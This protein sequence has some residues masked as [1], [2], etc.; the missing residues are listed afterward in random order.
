MADQQI[1]TEAQAHAVLDV[2]GKHTDKVQVAGDPVAEAARRKSVEDWREAAKKD[3]RGAAEMMA[4]K[5]DIPKPD[6]VKKLVA[7]AL[8]DIDP[9]HPDFAKLPQAEKDRYIETK[10]TALAA[11]MLIEGKGINGLT[12]SPE[13]SKELVNI[14]E[15][16]RQLATITPEGKALFAKLNPTE[17]NALIDALS[18]DPQVIE[19]IRTKFDAARES[20]KIPEKME[21]NLRKDMEDAKDTLDLAEKELSDL[22]ADLKRA[23]DEYHE[24]SDPTTPRGSALDTLHQE[25]P[26][27]QNNANEANAKLAAANDKVNELTNRHKEESAKVYPDRDQGRID[28]AK[29]LMDDA[30]LDRS[31]IIGE[32]KMW[33]DRLALYNNLRQ[34]RDNARTEAKSL[35]GQIL[36]Q[37]KAVREA[38][39]TYTTADKAHR[40]A[41]K[42]LNEARETFAKDM[43]GVIKEGMRAHLADAYTKNEQKQRED[44]T[45]AKTESGSKAQ[46]VIIKKIENSYLIPAHRKKFGLFGKDTQDWK[47]DGRNL[48]IDF[49]TLMYSNDPKTVLK[50]AL[51]GEIGAGKA[52][53]GVTEADIDEMLKEPWAQERG[54]DLA[55]KIIEKR[56]ASGKMTRGQIERISQTKWGEGLVTRAIQSNE[57][58]KAQI[59]TLQEQGILHGDVAE[60]FSKNP[61]LSIAA[62]ILA[63]LGGAATA[64]LAPAT[65]AGMGGAAAAFAGAHMAPTMAFGG[66]AAAVAEK[67]RREAA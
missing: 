10:N 18:K 34:A 64:G 4:A 62:M 60:W 45:K 6:A 40:G 11:V 61:H 26:V 48:A 66:A 59:T 19:Q 51:M 52:L 16:L 57:A 53:Q 3:T 54:Q 33:N 65:V 30:I 13:A 24:L 38:K 21:A 8:L 44:L 67:Y 58:L 12:T 41:E 46:D 42:T 27:T 63:I 28:A 49:K 7:D 23:N 32:A 14:R 37:T 29:T 2:E 47:L 5:E 9:S 39:E 31:P 17:Q 20:T 35:N 56:I 25:L 55:A 1:D 50:G 15:S 43:K 22:K 36:E